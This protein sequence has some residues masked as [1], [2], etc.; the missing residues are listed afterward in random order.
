[1][2]MGTSDMWN[3]QCRRLYRP[4]HIS[5]AEIDPT[6]I[7]VQYTCMYIEPPRQPGFYTRI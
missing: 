3:R 1:M 2:F 6:G 4:I 5:L 7:H